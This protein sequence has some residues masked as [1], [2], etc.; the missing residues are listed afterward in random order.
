MVFRIGKGL[1]AEDGVGEARYNEE[2][3]RE[4]E[5]TQVSADPKGVVLGKLERFIEARMFSSVRLSFDPC[6]DCDGTG[7]RPRFHAH[8]ETAYVACGRCAGSGKIQGSD[9]HP[10][11]A[12]RIREELVRRMAPAKLRSGW[13]IKIALVD[14]MTLRLTLKD[15]N[16]EGAD[17]RRSACVGLHRSARSDG[18]RG[19][20]PEASVS[21]RKKPPPPSLSEDDGGGLTTAGHRAAAFSLGVGRGRRGGGPRRAPWWRRAPSPG[22]TCS[23]PGRSG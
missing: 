6:P 12:Q 15:P 5:S 19:D 21:Q 1:I 7:V 9:I 3:R 17:F 13:E 8:R 20:G 22:P 11:D 10:E 16:G 18:V 23:G 2:A 4:E 14:M